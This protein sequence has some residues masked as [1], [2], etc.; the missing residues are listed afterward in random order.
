[1]IKYLLPLLF[2]PT[3]SFAANGQGEIGANLIDPLRMELKEAL[4]WCEKTP[5]A[6]KCDEVLESVEEEEY[7]VLTANFY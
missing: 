3:L 7:E 6:V 5:E 4:E 1:M 2:I